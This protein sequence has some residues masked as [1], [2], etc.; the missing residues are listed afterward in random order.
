MKS[1]FALALLC[2][3]AATPAAAQVKVV[4][5]WVRSTVPGQ[6]VAGAFMK[7]ESSVPASLVGAS[8]PIASRVEIHET[9]MKD[10]MASMRAVDK[11]DFGPGKPAVLKPGGYHVMLFDIAKPL[12]K[13][14]TVPLTLDFVEKGGKHTSVGIRAEVRQVGEGMKMDHDHMQMEMKK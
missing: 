7:L 10:N 4:Q 11:I 13:G 6:T 8:S 5:P 1:R 12:K 2:A 3:L 9:V 14:D